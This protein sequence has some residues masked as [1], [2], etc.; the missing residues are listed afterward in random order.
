ME[1]AGWIMTWYLGYVHNLYEIRVFYSK[2]SPFSLLIHHIY[3][4][5]V[6]IDETMYKERLF[7]CH[8]FQGFTVS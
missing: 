7:S 6:I 5:C 8:S 3:I 4:I 2:Y 1:P